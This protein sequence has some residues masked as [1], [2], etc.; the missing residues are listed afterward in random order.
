MH[1]RLEKLEKRTKKIKE[2]LKIKGTKENPINVNSPA[3]HD[4]F[5]TPADIFSETIEP[6]KLNFDEAK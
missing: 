3:F 1:P 4:A 6:K 5:A 2:Y